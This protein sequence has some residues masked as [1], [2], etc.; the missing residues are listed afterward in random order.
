MNHTC[1]PRFTLTRFLAL[2]LLS[3]CVLQA[4]TAAQEPEPADTVYY[5]TILYLI[6]E[7]A[8][9][10]KLMQHEV[11]GFTKAE[12]WPDKVTSPIY[13][14]EQFRD[15]KNQLPPPDMQTL[16]YFGRGLSRQ[17]AE[18]LQQAELAI[19]LT[20]A[21][22]IEQNIKH[23]KALNNFSHRLA[24]E[25]GG[26]LWDS[27][28]RELFTPDVWKVQRLDAWHGDIPLAHQHTVIHAY[29]DTDY[30]RAIT[31]GMAKFG[32]PDIVVNKF[33]W[34][35]NR[36]MGNLINIVAQSLAEGVVP[37]ADGRLTLNIDQLADT[38][39]KKE[40]LESLLD[41][42]ERQVTLSIASGKWEEGDP[43][44]ILLELTFHDIEGRDLHAK[45]E[46]LLSRLFGWEDS[47]VY[48]EQNKQ[49]EA[50]SNRAKEKLSLLKE[51]F[52]KGL[53]PGEYILLKAPFE[54]PDGGTEWMWVEVI[55]WRD[56]SIKGLLKNEPFKIPDLHG[57]AEVTVSQKDIF[58]Y[59]WNRADGSREGNETGELIQK[60]Q[61][62]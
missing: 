31:L 54:T 45:Q 32:L 24:T 62:Q 60:Y 42:A 37:E 44:N 4:N 61:N 14:L 21:Y 56:D 29:Q 6:K 53:N 48:V 1:C 10:G 47:I 19:V 59:I 16:S 8:N 11:P 46:A 55:T 23:L 51:A 38:P 52:N 28:T 43:Q 22:P 9:L 40:M 25:N 20:A 57:G 26:Y 7:P 30:V 36:S 13:R 49:I 35:S 39:F 12:E 2:T 41:N 18:E 5:Q 15:L 34:S 3:L 50:A 17:E 58:D 27:E 33:S